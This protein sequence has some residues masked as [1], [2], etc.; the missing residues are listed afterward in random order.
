MFLCISVNP[1]I[2]KRLRMPKFA[3]GSV[4][5][6]T[7]VYPAPG[8]KAAHVAMVLRALATKPV[9]LG[10]SGGGSGDEVVRGLE[11]LGIETEAIAT[12]DST[13]TNLEIVE[14][15]GTVTEVLEPGPVINS[16]ELET[17]RR[18]CGERFERGGSE[19]CVVISGSLPQGVPRDFYATLLADAR[20]SLCKVFLDTSGEPLRRALSERPDFVKPNRHEAEWLFGANIPDKEAASLAVRR[21]LEAGAKSAAISL[22]QDGLVW[23]PRIDSK[24]YFAKAPVV[25]AGSAVGSGDAVMAAFAY[26]ASLGMG[27]EDA[28]RLAVACGAANCLANLPGRLHAADVRELQGEV[29]VI[30]I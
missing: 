16:D 26:S 14:D 4:N 9:W 3:R 23:C 1:A 18:A 2:D 12:G 10:F 20:R 30:T 13:R 29:R 17:F 5:R 22:G 19:A 6:A 28:V 27:S 21:I 8:G 11:D 7:E 25:K 15:D 24:V